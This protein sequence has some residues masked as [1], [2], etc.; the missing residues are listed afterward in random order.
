VGDEGA[1]AT[2]FGQRQRLAI[3]GL[4]ALG[5]E[6]VGMGRDVAE[7]VQRIGYDAMTRRRPF[8][9]AFA[10]TLRLVEPAKQQ[11]GTT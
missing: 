10:Q 1:H 11:S 8:E 7:Q 9:Y 4:P 5:I 2:G 6:A 3:V